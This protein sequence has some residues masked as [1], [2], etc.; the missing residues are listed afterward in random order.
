[1]RPLTIFFVAFAAL[2]LL[3]PSG[4]TAQTPATP[5]QFELQKLLPSDGEEG[6]LFG[7]AVAVSG[8][9]AVIGAATDDDN[10]PGSGAAYVFRFDGTTWVEEAKLI[11]SDGAAYDEFGGA[12]AISDDV[13]VIGAPLS[14]DNGFDSGSA[15]V[16]RLH[17]K[18]WVEE[19]KLLAS[20]AAAGD[21]FGDAVGISGDA[22]VIGARGDV[23][24]GSQSGSA[25]VFR[26]HGNTWVE[27]AKLIASDAEA[28]DAFGDAVAISGH[29]A[30]IGAPRDD[31]N[32]SQSGSAYVFR[33]DGKTWLEEAKLRA[34]DG[35]PGDAFG[36]AVAISGDA[37]VIGAGGSKRT[38]SAY[39]FR[40]GE[41]TWVEE[42][43]LLASDGAGRF[44]DAVSIS[45]DVAV[46]GAPWEDRNYF[47]AAYVFGF[48][49]SSWVEEAKL[50]AS[51]GA[52]EDHLGNAVA[53]S[54]DA[55]VTGASFGDDNGSA[56]GA[57]YIFELGS[58]DPRRPGTV[59]FETAVSFAAGDFARSVA[60]A[61]LDGDSVPDLV[62]VAHS[63]VS[64]LLGNGDGTFQTAV[65]FALGIGLR[66][67]AVADLDGDG[68]PDLAIADFSRDEV[69]VLLGNGDGSFQ[70][71]AYFAV[72]DSPRSVA[73]ADLDGDSVPD[74]VTANINSDDVSVLLG[75]GDGSFQAAVAFA[76]GYGPE[77]AAV[78]DLDGDSV[79]DLVIGNAFS[80]DVSVLLGNGDGTFQT[81]V[82]FEAGPG[83]PS[84]VSEAVGDLNGD[85]FP[86]LVLV[87][88]NQNSVDVRV[89]LGNGDGTFQA[90]APHAAGNGPNSVAVADLDGDSVPDL[91]TANGRGGDVTVLLGNGNG[92]FQRPIAFAAGDRPASVAVAD[93]DG[94]N[95]PDLVTANTDSQDVSVLLQV[96]P[97]IEIDIK[98][99]SDPNSI[100]LSL[101]GDLPVAI[102]GSDTFDV[103]DV[104][105]TTLAFGPNGARLVHWRGPH[106][107]D[108][109]GDGVTDLLAHFRVEETGIAFGDMEACVTGE[110][111]GG[112][113]FNGCDSVRTVPDMDGD[114]LLDVD[115]A[116]IGTDALNPDTDGDGFEDGQEVHSMGTNPLDSLDPA[117][118]GVRGSRRRGRAGQ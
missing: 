72:G 28:F 61:D 37:A 87:T 116:T 3:L 113:R 115:E 36:G 78:A 53:I 14:N 75:N 10:G 47:G 21:V 34:S 1:M 81:A 8:G 66:S 59:F 71:A 106:F 44:G 108:V 101:E 117:P 60:V 20:D 98:P 18:T 32:G 48:D 63:S 33:F 23:V 41:R 35:A 76:A 29:A 50:L 2:A 90:A 97:P 40:F 13:V 89:L 118:K 105:V 70:A 69:S 58:L 51:D 80:H 104:D 102:L 62:T 22:A 25:Y 85:G 24:N 77:S 46:I 16:F 111:L 12:V 42:A 38:G 109:D 17:G 68:A 82:A 86:D 100:N 19:T 107:E 43:K 91:V 103:A 54:G 55:V 5:G 4:A 26:F 56:S 79:P 92:S 65:T 96:G 7:Y 73:V 114:G 84:V 67:L 39:V 88:A 64:V 110:T 95:L 112:M 9:V 74:L 94:D 57:A 45:G 93:L 83:F 30:V 52:A 11:A 6:D 49:G 99:G 27:D 15:Y 31:D